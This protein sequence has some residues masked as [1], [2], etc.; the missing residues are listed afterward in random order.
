MPVERPVVDTGVDCPGARPHLRLAGNIK[1]LQ[2]L[3]SSQD[4]ND[5]SSNRG[6]KRRRQQA[7]LDDAIILE[8]LVSCAASASSIRVLYACHRNWI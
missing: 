8:H 4:H 7:T 5:G 1:P 6:K 2:S 3:L